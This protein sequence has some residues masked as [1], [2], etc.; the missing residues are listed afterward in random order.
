MVVTEHLFLDAFDM[1]DD[2]LLLIQ[3]MIVNIGKSYPEFSETLP[4]SWLH[5]QWKLEHM[6]RNGIRI[7]PFSTLEEANS[8]LEKELSPE[9]LK[10]FV[11]FQ[12][13]SGFLL[14]F[15][16]PHLQ[17]LIVLDPKLIIDATKCVVTCQAFAL[18]VWGKREW[19]H[20]VGT[21]KVEKSYIR[22]IWKKR[23]KE[24][25]AKHSDYLLLVMEK[26]DIIVSPKVYEEGVNDEVS[27]VIVPCMLQGSAPEK[28]NVPQEEDVQMR[29]VFH[30]VLP[31]AI[32][33]RFVASCLALWPVQD[34]LYDGYAALRSG[35]QNVIVLTRESQSITLS[36]RNHSD[37][38]K[39]DI[40]LARSLQL[41]ISQ[42]MQRIVSLYSTTTAQDDTRLYKV[43][44]NHVATSYGI[45]RDED[46]VSI[47]L[48]I[49]F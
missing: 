35:P 31:P 4:V 41:Y 42:T 7:L 34:K 49:S 28:E 18:D 47:S 16:D 9:E 15:S 25:L 38:A 45:G 26:L 29:F 44:Y 8:T 2:S 27:F 10:L 37:A 3:S 5:L 36:V 32:Y 24:V 30:D 12:H 13:N 33:N 6:R 17:H 48:I 43:E 39:V 11:S 14:H 46:L 1:T 21:G 20:M 23:S 19:E 22:K 40:H